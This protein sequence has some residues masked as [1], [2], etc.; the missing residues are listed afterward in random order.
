ME[1][2][3]ISQTAHERSVARADRWAKILEADKKWIAE[4]R[5]KYAGR[6][7]ETKQADVKA[8]EAKVAAPKLPVVAKKKEPSHGFVLLEAH[9]MVEEDDWVLVD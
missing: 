3:I 6:L 9:E 8:T 5:N 7:L 2:A 1:P 4:N